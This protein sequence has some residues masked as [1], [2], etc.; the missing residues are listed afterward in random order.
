[1]AAQAQPH[2]PRNVPPQVAVAGVQYA[3]AAFKKHGPG[4]TIIDT[5][6]GS[7]TFVR[8]EEI[9]AQFPQMPQKALDGMLRDVRS[10]FESV[11]QEGLIL[12]KDDSMFHAYKVPL[13]TAE[14][15]AS[16]DDAD[17]AR[18]LHVAQ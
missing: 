11:P 7:T 2:I 13:P 16:G 6:R 10:G 17:Q 3:S 5:T 12:V 1:M 14:P 8:A 9:R 4:L 15:A 18:A